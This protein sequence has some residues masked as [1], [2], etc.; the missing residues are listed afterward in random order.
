MTVYY[1]YLYFQ[2]NGTVLYA[3]T[4]DAPHEMIRRFSKMMITK[5]PDKAAV[6]GHYQVRKNIV[7]VTAQQQW[8]VVRLELSIQPTGRALAFDRHLSTLNGDFDDYRNVVEHKVPNE[9]F[10]YLKDHRL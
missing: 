1:R 6:W 3:L 2:E 9:F 5:I 10:R 8:Q 7:T 4:N